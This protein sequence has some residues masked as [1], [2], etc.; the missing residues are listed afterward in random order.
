MSIDSAVLVVGYQRP[1]EVRQILSKVSKAGI[2]SVY[3]SIDAPKVSSS[4][5]L[6]R[7]KELRMIVEE[8][9]EKFETFTSRF[10]PI[11]VGCSAN[12]LS[13]CDW[14]FSQE[15]KLIILE[16]DCI[17]S[18][19]FFPYVDF[20]FK[21]MIEDPEVLLICGTQFQT[22]K[23]DESYLIKSRYSLTWGWA[24]TKS[25]WELL[26]K[27]FSQNSVGVRS[28]LLTFD[29]EQIY[30]NEGAR[31]ALDG[32]VDVWDTVLVD[33][34]YSCKGYAYLPSQ[35]LVKNIGNDGV[36]TH[37]GSDQNWVNTNTGNFKPNLDIKII[38]GKDSDKWLKMNFFRIQPRHLIST[39]IT[40]LVDKIKEPTLSPLRIR[41]EQA[42]KY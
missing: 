10:L 7:S 40:R 18:D 1:N 31:R 17:P 9:S 41:W 36:A 15:D 34:L 23:S 33:Y 13:A 6:T 2:K 42:A 11:N 38:V 39:R 26:R 21:K 16:D 4:E 8:F 28:N 19:D 22:C 29:Y 30:W 14:A 20:A 27:S 37:T 25:N 5:A 35:N 12:I 32:Y 24:T 3:L